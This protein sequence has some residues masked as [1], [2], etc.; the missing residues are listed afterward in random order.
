MQH[1]NVGCCYTVTVEN[2]KINI[3]YEICT[4]VFSTDL[5][6]IS[7]CFPLH[8][9]NWPVFISEMACL[10]RTVGNQSLNVSQGKFGMATSPCQSM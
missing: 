4:N 2:V 7:N 9:T 1:Q 3:N 5:R 10:H 6:T 8:S